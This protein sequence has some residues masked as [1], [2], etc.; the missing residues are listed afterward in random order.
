MKP[1]LSQEQM[2]NLCANSGSFQPGVK[3]GLQAAYSLGY[4]AGGAQER[5]KSVLNRA[6]VPLTKNDA[7]LHLRIEAYLKQCAPHVAARQAPQLLTEAL[8]AIRAGSEP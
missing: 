5:L 7:P 8:A 4:A 1:E 3:A 2:L 6:A